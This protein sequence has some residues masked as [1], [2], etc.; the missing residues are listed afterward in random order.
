MENMNNTNNNMSNNNTMEQ[1]A[2]QALASAIEGVFAAVERYEREKM[3]FVITRTAHFKGEEPQGV[4]IVE[5]LDFAELEQFGFAPH[6]NFLRARFKGNH[7]HH[8]KWTEEMS[9]GTILKSRPGEYIQ[10]IK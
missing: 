3:V 7:G 2:A 10:R 4:A 8:T 1:N 6:T 5:A 9:V